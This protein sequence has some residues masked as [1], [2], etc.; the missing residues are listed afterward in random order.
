MSLCRFYVTIAKIR[1]PPHFT[2]SPLVLQCTWPLFAFYE[3]RCHGLGESILRCLELTAGSLMR[4]H[5]DR[6]VYVLAEQTLVRNK[7][8]VKKDE[9][10]LVLF[11]LV[12]KVI[13]IDNNSIIQH[14]AGFTRIR[15]KKKNPIHPKFII[16]ISPMAVSRCYNIDAP[17]AFH[18][19]RD[20]FWKELS[21][22][23]GAQCLLPY[24][25][26]LLSPPIRT[27]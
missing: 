12:L 2:A 15:C 5:Y 6:H 8:A 10:A 16:I 26:V 7:I 18:E 11:R 1:S 21:L 14:P 25:W 24:W 3:R 22:S 27:G 17:F 20:S 19:R 23:F 13:S 9:V 4:W